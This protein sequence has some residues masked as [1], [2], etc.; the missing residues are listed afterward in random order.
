MKK[1]YRISWQNQTLTLGKN[2]CIMGILNVTPDSFSDGGQFFNY[3]N[4]VAR[5]KQM[6]EQ[7]ADIIDIGGESSRPYADPVSTEEE[8]KRVV[9]VIEAISKAIQVPISIDTV[10][11]EVAKKAIEAGASIVN[12]ISALTGDP[13]M[14]SVVS[15]K[16]VPVILMHMLGTPRTMQDNPTYRNPVTEIITYLKNTIRDAVN[17]NI[18]RSKIIIDPGIGFG[19]T[20]DHNYSLLKYLQEFSS[21]DVPILVGTS[22]KRFIR[23]TV[24][25]STKDPEPASIE[26]GTQ[27]TV[28]ASI[29]NGAHIVRVHDVASTVHTV[30]VADAIKNGIYDFNAS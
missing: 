24:S 19:K 20:L 9:P 12:D 16:G 3:T 25:D 23:E 11:A 18:S 14:A 7:G 5:A 26:T 10:K 28:T 2:T 22:R 17:K 30:K 1:E 29:L 6:V 21:L 8:I 27:A 13:E 15:E 4:A